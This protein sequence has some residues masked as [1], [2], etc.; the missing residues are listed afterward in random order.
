MRPN[1]ISATVDFARDGIQH[2][3]LRL[4]NSTNESAW[5]VVPIPITVIRNGEGPTVLLTGANH[6]DEYEGPLALTDLAN[7]LR[8]EQITGRTI[9][10]PFMNH[11]AFLAGTRTS[12]LDGGNMNRTFPG[13]PDGG[14]TGK[15]AD[16]FARTL[17]P[18]ADI[19]LDFHSGG[20]T[21][22]F[23][24]FA[25][26][27]I[28]DD[29]EQEA[30]CRAARDAFNAPWSV[31]MREIDALGMYDDAAESQGKTFVTTELGGGGTSRVETVAIARRG[32]RNLLIHAG[33]MTGEQ[34]RHPSR[35]LTQPGS[36]CFVFA[37]YGGMIEYLC[38]LGAPVSEGDV[39]ARIWMTG[40]T[41]Q[42]P[43][44]ITSKM[45]GIFL[46]RHFPGLV[47]PGDCVAVLAVE[48]G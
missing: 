1:P 48:D 9:I 34:T 31:E 27:H 10:V 25:A 4:P 38:D 16:Y 23:I 47:R 35:R 22:D 11:P 7:N 43:Q 45:D 32:V 39:L 6:G 29:Q 3:H 37:E 20:R 36:E 13:A 28:L 41:G 19:V 5:G 17:L 40:R 30:R 33:I 24:P 21:L 8:A 12:P 42:A 2:G 26:S 44:D 15:I 46:G 14:A 18:M